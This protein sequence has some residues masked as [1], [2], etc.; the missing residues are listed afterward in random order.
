VLCL[1]AAHLGVSGGRN[2]A[3]AQAGCRSGIFQRLLDMV[4]GPPETPVAFVL[5]RATLAT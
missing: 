4:D 1:A 2:T 5:N 3:A